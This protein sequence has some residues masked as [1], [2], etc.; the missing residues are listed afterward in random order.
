MGGSGKSFRNGFRE[1]RTE[2]R[3]KD[4]ARDGVTFL[5]RD[6]EPEG[7]RVGRANAVCVDA[8]RWR[9]RMTQHT[10]GGP[11]GRRGAGDLRFHISTLIGGQNVSPAGHAMSIRGRAS[12]KRLSPTPFR[13]L[14]LLRFFS[15]RWFP[16]A[17]WRQ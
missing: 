17:S 2:V 12:V 11:G 13:A 9:R 8:E 3:D 16:R 7:G 4:K 10:N 5:D 14:A 1:G 6:W 15:R